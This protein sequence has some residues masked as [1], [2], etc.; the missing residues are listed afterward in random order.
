MDF[1]EEPAYFEPVQ[2]LHTLPSQFVQKMHIL[3]VFQNRTGCPIESRG[4]VITN[5]RERVL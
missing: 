2:K 3:N 5:K 1:S 4:F